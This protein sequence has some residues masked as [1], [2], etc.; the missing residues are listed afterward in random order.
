MWD[1]FK[2][3]YIY[4]YTFHALIH[5]TAVTFNPNFAHE[6]TGIQRLVSSWVL[7]LWA[8]PHSN[9]GHFI[10]APEF[11]T[12]HNYF[13][14]ASPHG[15]VVKNLPASA[16]DTRDTGSIPGLGR[17]PRGGNGNALQY[18]CLENPKDRGTFLRKHQ[19]ICS[20]KLFL[21]WFTVL[22][23]GLILIFAENY[24]GVV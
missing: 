20:M 4:C 2:K 16:G 5:L 18:S 1:F 8:E 22:N 10:L 23:L 17:S 7:L 14:M 15:S 21:L 24:M 3:N 13:S 6:G 11:L 19:M 9:P 12:M